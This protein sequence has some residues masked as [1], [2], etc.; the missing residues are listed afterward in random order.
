[1]TSW[2]WAVHAGRTQV[3]RLPCLR[4][5]LV[6]LGK[7]TRTL[8]HG[9]EMDDTAQATYHSLTRG[10]GAVGMAVAPRW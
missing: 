4:S 7:H 2:A 8:Q 3:G 6:A 9:R 1:M 10:G 5:L